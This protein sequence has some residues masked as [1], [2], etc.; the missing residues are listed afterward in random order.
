MD[1]ALL[2]G[3]G[4]F[5]VD[6]VMSAPRL[7]AGLFGLQ[8]LMAATLSWS[9]TKRAWRWWWLAAAAMLAVTALFFALGNWGT[10][11]VTKLSVWFA[12]PYVQPGEPFWNLVGP[13]IPRLPYRMAAVHG[14][15]AAGYGL[16]AILL[17]LHWQRPSWAGWWCLF[18]TCSPILRG[19]LQNGQTRQALAVL[20][21]LPLML[22]VAQL[23]R[24]PWGPVWGATAW[25]ALT[26]TTFPVNLVFALLPGLVDSK[27]LGRTAGMLRGRRVGLLLL[28]LVALPALLV[29]GPVA[30]QKLNTYAVEVGFF[31]SYAI[32]RE[33][34][35]LQA[36]MALAVVLSCRVRS[37]G[38]R[39]LAACLHSRVLALF[40]LLYLALQSSVAWEWW[41]QITFRLADSAGL[42]LLIT[43]LA[44]L[45]HYRAERLLLPALAVTLAYWLLG[46]IL[47]SGEFRCGQDD[48]F[49]CIPDRWPGLVRY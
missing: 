11:D 29:V 14:L 30:W 36:A 9:G 6:Q 38:P 45:C 46:R 26:H 35:W 23:V 1:L 5:R 39:E 37:L 25:S 48:S 12:G 32:R 8:L 41:P 42:F 4:P 17:A 49:L 19:A 15:V 20:L 43:F 18:L 10:S 31:S 22:R 28:C 40:S 24:L 3:H 47:P 33:V 7:M 34:L 44:W 2:P 13:L 16:A 27:Q 21:L